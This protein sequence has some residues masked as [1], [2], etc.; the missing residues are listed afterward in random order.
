MKLLFHIGRG[1][2]FNNSG[3]MTFEGIDD[4]TGSSFYVNQE[5]YYPH[6][7]DYDGND[8]LDENG[9]WIEDDSDDAQV[10]DHNGN[11]VGLTF[12]ELYEGIGR[13][14]LDGDYDTWIAIHSDDM[15][16]EHIQAI[17]RHYKAERRLLND[18]IELLKEVANQNDNYTD[19]VIELFENLR[20]GYPGYC[21]ENEFMQKDVDKWIEAHKEE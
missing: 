3:Y 11:E 13:I 15:G 8:V 17:I 21:P 1:G 16:E 20:I 7:K 14:D 19:D 18:D 12:G 5:Y 9:D 10:L 2:R 4:L 6:L